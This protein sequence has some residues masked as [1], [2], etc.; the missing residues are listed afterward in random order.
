MAT[1]P[2]G[3]YQKYGVDDGRQ[4]RGRGRGHR[5]RVG[6]G[7]R[8]PAWASLI[9]AG[10]R[11][12]SRRRASWSRGRSRACWLGRRRA[13]PLAA[14]WAASSAWASPRSTRTIYAEGV[15]RGGTLVTVTVDETEVQQV[16]DLLDR[17]GA[18]DI[19][20][21][22]DYYRQHG[23]H[24][25]RPDAQ[26]LTTPSEIA[27]ERDLLRAYA[28]DET[29]STGIGPAASQ[30]RIKTYAYADTP[31]SAN[32]SSH[33][34]SKEGVIAVT[35]QA[36]T[37]RSRPALL[38]GAGPIGSRPGKSRHLG[39]LLGAMALALNRENYLLH[40]I[41]SLT[42]VVP[43][44]YYMA[45]HLLLNTFSVAG[46]AKFNAVLAFFEGIPNYVLLPWRRPRSGFRSCSTRSTASSSRA[47]PSRTSSAPSTAGRR[48]GCTRSSATAASSSSSS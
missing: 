34:R 15:R 32:R 27:A 47:A 10:R 4:P 29:L 20:Q 36:A 48:T 19:E 28:S 35:F 17:D 14:S 43:V 40:K 37:M 2:S 3:E 38:L 26:P 1:D 7:G 22:G 25:L 44:G 5:A 18:V 6:D 42:G 11:S 24:R 8:R 33:P 9:G 46:P 45:Q 30:G 13:R 12:S 16:R 39:T 31:T 41:H 21:R 23:L